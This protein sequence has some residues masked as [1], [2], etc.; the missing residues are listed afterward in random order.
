[1]LQLKCANRAR[2]EGWAVAHVSQYVGESEVGRAGEGHSTR[3]EVRDLEWMSPGWVTDSGYCQIQ[4]WESAWTSWTPS[5]VAALTGKH[6]GW[7]WDWDS[8][9]HVEYLFNG[10]QNTTLSA[11][12]CSKP[13]RLMNVVK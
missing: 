13:S 2:T 8:T 9:K 3:C 6:Q 11:R 4:C 12:L 10:K 7:G 1:M 5:L